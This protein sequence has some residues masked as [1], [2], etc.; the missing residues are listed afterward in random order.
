[1][2]QVVSVDLF[3]VPQDSIPAFI[4]ESKTVRNIVKNIPGLVE[5]YFYE[6]TD[7]DNDY[8]F[9]TMAVWENE[10]VFENAGKA[11]WR[12]F[13]E[14]DFNPQDAHTKLGIKRVRSEY[15]RSPY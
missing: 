6:K 11:I 8:N 2:S 9:M 13:Q 5:G 12:A 3:I 10:E 15:S 4:Q 14:Q 1:M 7:G